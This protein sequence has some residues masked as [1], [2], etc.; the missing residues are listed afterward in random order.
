MRSAIPSV[1]I[2]EYADID[3]FERDGWRCHLCGKKIA[4]TASRMSA[5]GATIDHLIPLSLGGADAPFNV[6]AAHRRC[7]A[8]KSTAAR[9]DQ[10][11]LV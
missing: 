4:R 2:V 9:N 7:N 10:L 8:A 1:E 6:A 5:N 11:R 3:I